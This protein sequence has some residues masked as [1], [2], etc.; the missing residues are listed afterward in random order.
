MQLIP[1]FA[2]RTSAKKSIA[3]CDFYQIFKR[4]CQRIRISWAPHDFDVYILEDHNRACDHVLDP[5]LH[6]KNPY[7]MAES[8]FL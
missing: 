3:V 5:G 4:D 7:L 8:G 6:S 1:R 2:I